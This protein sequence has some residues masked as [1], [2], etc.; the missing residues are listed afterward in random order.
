MNFRPGVCVVPGM[1]RTITP[2]ATFLATLLTSLALLA[3]PA[4]ADAPTLP[5]AARPALLLFAPDADN[6]LLRQQLNVYERNRKAFE[7]RN[8]APVVVLPERLQTPEGLSLPLTPQALQRRFD[9]GPYQFRAFVI[10]P[11]G[12]MLAQ[13]ETP[14]SQPALFEIVAGWPQGSIEAFESPSPK[15]D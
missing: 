11:Q 14:F 15:A 5:Q 1:R 3:A 13:A 8:L 9:V 7:A 2:L 4:S 6:R 10:G 12:R